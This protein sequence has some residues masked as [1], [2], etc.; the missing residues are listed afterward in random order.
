MELDCWDGANNHPQIYHGHT[1]TTRLLFRDVI[2]TINDYAFRTS[3]YPV[4][5]S[6]EN[7]CS[8]PQ[9]VVMAKV[10]LSTFGDR[11]I[12]APLAENETVLPSPESLRYK[13]L[14]KASKG[15]P[16]LRTVQRGRAQKG[17]GGAL[18]G[19]GACWGP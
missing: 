17:S 4:I 7:H 1:L 16:H 5:L 12:Q 3:P 10:M 13:I 18:E 19:S 6:F 11:L 9:Q 2:T 15:S 14:V 8:V